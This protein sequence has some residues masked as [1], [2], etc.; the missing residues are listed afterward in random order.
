MGVWNGK[1]SLHLICLIP[2]TSSGH[3]ITQYMQ[4]ME[5]GDPSFIGNISSYEDAMLAPKT[6]KEVRANIS[7]THALPTQ[8]YNPEGFATLEN[9]GTSHISAADASGLAISLTTTINLFFGSKVMVPETGVIMNDE[10]ND[11]SIPHVK[12]VFG[13]EPSP[14]NFIRPGKRPL[15]SMSPTIVEHANGTLY[16][17]IGAAGGSRIPTAVI[18]Q[19]WYVLDRNMSVATALEEP[20]FHDQLQPDMMALEW[21]QDEDAGGGWL[22]EEGQQRFGY[23]NETAAYLRELG[24]NVTWMAP[25][26]SSVQGVRMLVNGTFEAAGEPRQLTSGGFAV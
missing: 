26:T 16:F 21:P 14:A 7:D 17:V 18:Q 8:H 11:F 6:G 23:S 13:Y 2:I 22:L 24:H 3:L 10:M 5:L 9:H 4:R 19:L 25:H 20:R 12:N 15:S 1:R